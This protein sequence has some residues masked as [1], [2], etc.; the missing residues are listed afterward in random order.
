[1]ATDDIAEQPL[2]GGR[3][4]PGVVRVGDTVRRPLGPHSPF[5]HELLRLLEHREETGVPRLLGVDEQGREILSFVEGWVPP[6]LEGRAWSDDQVAEA[7]RLVRRFHDA[8]AGSAIAGAEEVVRHR[9]LS[10]CNFAFH[11]GLPRGLID[12]DRAEPGSRRSDL[13]YMAWMWLVGEEIRG[14]PS[15]SHRMR[16]LRLLLD[17]YGLNERDRFADAILA[18]QLEVRELTLQRGSLPHWVDAEI[19]F[20]RERADLITRAAAA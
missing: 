3:I 15:F 6:D 2:A 9:D 12:F 14:E 7:A 13:A 8:T 4:T 5:V 10:P 16:Q 1:M 11:H 17:S 20:V 18:E 19:A